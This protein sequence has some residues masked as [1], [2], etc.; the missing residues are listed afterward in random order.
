[1]LLEAL[2]VDSLESWSTQESIFEKTKGE[3]GGKDN[4]LSIQISYLG[5]S[6]GRALPGFKHTV[7]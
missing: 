5:S 6:T 4:Y 2:N 7:A 3:G 1:M